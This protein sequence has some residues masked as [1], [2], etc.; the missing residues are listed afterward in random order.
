MFHRIISSSNLPTTFQKIPIGNVVK[1]RA[2]KHIFPCRDFTRIGFIIVLFSIPFFAAAQSQHTISG[3]IKDKQS[4]ELL[5]GATVI[6]KELKNVGASS[7]A[8][9]FYSLTLPEGTYTILVQYLGYSTITDTINLDRDKTINFGL[10]SGTINEGEVVVSAERSNKNVTSTEMSTTNLEVKEVQNIPVLFGEKDVMKTIQLLPGIEATGEGNTDFYARGGGPDQNLILLDEA[11]VYNPSHLLGFLSVF[12]S[13]AIKDVKLITGGMPAEY[14]GRLSSVVDIRTDDG[15][16]KEFEGQ[17]GVGLLESNLTVD[18]PIVKDKGSFLVSARRTYADLFLHLSRDTSI[19]RTSLYFYDLNAKANYTFGEQDRVFL[20][21]YFGRD[22][23]GY[24]NLF[25][26]NWGNETGTLRWNHLFSDVLFSNTSLIY[27]NYEYTSSVGSGTSEFGI[28]SGIKDVNFKTDFQYF[29]N[30]HHTI[31]F[32][33]NSIYH[34]FLPGTVTISPSSSYNNISIEHRYALED[35]AYLSDDADLSSNFK[36]TYG[37]RFSAFS[38]LGP[39]HID[40][41]DADGNVIDSTYY[42]SG[43]VIKTYTSIEPRIAAT[44]L[45]NETSSLKASY[46]RTSQFLHLL[47]NSITTFPS[48][49]WVPSS[50]NV[51]PEYADQVDLGYFKNFS[52]NAFESSVEVYYKNMQNLIDYKNGADL[53]LNPNV[54]ALLLYGRGWSYGAEF[55]IRKKAGPLSGWLAYTLSRTEE[56][57]GAINNGQPFP[58]TQDR[59]HDISLVLIYDYNSEWTFSATW[60][61]YTGNAVTFPSGGYVI[62]DL[63][64]PKWIPLYTERNGYRM[65]PYNRLDLS[66]TWTLGPRSSLNFSIYN[67]YDRWNPYSINFQVDPNDPNKIQA[68]QTTL[69][70]IIP[71]ISYN[72]RF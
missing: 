17:G 7:N 28:T 72:F 44:M 33:L 60:V 31:S 61:Y 66:A 53:Q 26:V 46:T 41:Y 1:N 52:D 49:V 32:G 6:V 4:G 68:V 13:D 43:N 11:T 16:M 10:T 22:N 45:L 9:G 2:I 30:S 29:L 42:G 35:A 70:P 3:T 40:T 5:I 62:N 39:G 55:L 19:N 27:S 71:S 57:F 24:P 18:G 69:F 58:A 56:Q 37:L 21:G 38:L 47:S 48:D 54:E 67:A 63:G 12:N 64:E 15:N 51:K 59:T 65:P 20:S 36:L 50:N 14:G 34:T 25:G 8:Y 23:L